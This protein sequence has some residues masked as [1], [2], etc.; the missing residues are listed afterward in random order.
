SR[1]GHEA[2]GAAWERA[3]ELTADAAA[4]ARRLHEAAESAWLTAD[5]VRAD[6][7][8]TAALALARE[9]LLRADI[10]LLRA[11]IEWNT[12][13]LQAGR[14]LVLEGAKEVAEADPVRARELA[15]FGAALGSFDHSGTGLNPLEI[16]TEPGPAAPARQKC[17]WHLLAG[18]HHVGTGDLARGA[19]LLRAAYADG[20]SLE[21]AD[22]DLLPN[23][24]IAAVLLGDDQAALEY[25]GLLL[26][27]ARAGG[28]LMMALYAL[29]RRHITDV[30]TGN[31]A[32]AR[33]G[34]SEALQLAN[35]SGQAGLTAFPL[36]ALTLLD[37]LQSEGSYTR[38]LGAAEDVAAKQP[39]GSMHSLVHDVLLWAKAVESGEPEAA[40]HQLARFAH[41]VMRHTAAVDRVEAAFRSGHREEAAAWTAE[42][43]DYA[44]ATGNAW[45]AAAAAHCQALLTEGEEAERLYLAALEHHA[46]SPRSFDRARTQ[47]AYGEYLRRARR[48][49]DARSHLSAALETFRELGARRW[50]ER[51]Q[52]EMR[53]SGKTAR[54]REPSAVVVLTP[55]ER[56]VAAL[57]QQ[58]LSNRDAA[59]QLFLSPRTVDFHLR[60][61]YAKLGI[62][63][64]GE[65]MRRQLDRATA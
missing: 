7:L 63:N 9:P 43:Q 1:G 53:A 21:N 57:I 4:K 14:H 54:K 35:G 12:G 44:A 29:T 48:R 37:A 13:S 36:A 52:Q 46:S 20:A 65:L 51:T 34:A 55:Q 18:F 39:L 8:N 59:A 2:A 38:H 61:V 30:V 64:R 25:H 10:A 33:A 62:S 56:Q 42:T 6:R 15:M 32:A 45:A 17:F 40:F 47:L 26:S 22:Q 11:R 28:A 58:G 5:T 27:R 19:A 41:P 31:W 3:A 50:E 60:N 23:L 49:V 16:A 24:G